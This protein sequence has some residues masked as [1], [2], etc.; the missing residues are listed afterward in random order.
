[1]E[2]AERFA[3]LV[4]AP[5]AEL[6][7]DIATFCISASVRSAV[8]VDAQC[9][10]LDELAAQ[11]AADSFAAVRD[12]LFTVLGF[13]GDNQD[14]RDPRNSFLDAVIDR[15]RGIPI[16]LSVLLIEVA[17]RRGIA[18]HGIGMPGHFVV[19]EAAT[20]DR[21][22]DPF[23]GGVMLDRAGCARLFAA[24]TG[25]VRPLEDEDLRPTPSRAILA[26][27]LANLENGP[28]AGVPR[29]YATVCAL[30]LAI[31]GIPIEHQVDLLRRLA[32]GGA[33]EIVERAY[34]TVA[35]R[36]PE[37]LAAE[38]RAEA[39]VLHARWN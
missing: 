1:M 19:Q 17:R 20:P 2:P 10:R 13:R 35:E 37:A 6:R 18:V 11:C 38:L 31:P 3:S 22:C 9:A 24:T 32:R 34:E 36:A 29:A 25:A 27:M 5:E 12:Q 16:T 23:H 39:R 33:P 21:W 28:L 14:Y 4:R 30:H 15:R 8:D 26:R 7:L